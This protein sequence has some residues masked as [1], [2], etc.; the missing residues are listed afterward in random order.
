MKLNQT[1]DKKDGVNSIC[2]PQEKRTG[3][4]DNGE[5]QYGMMAGWGRPLQEDS[6]RLKMAE[7][8]LFVEFWFNFSDVLLYGVDEQGACMVSIIVL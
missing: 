3:G 7:W 6:G 8:T 1:I 5:Y 4:R 2:L